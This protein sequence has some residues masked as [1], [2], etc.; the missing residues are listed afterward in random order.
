VIFPVPSAVRFPNPAIGESDGGLPVVV[1]GI[2][3]KPLNL[4]EYV[5]LRLA[6]LKANGVGVAVGIAGVG[7]GV[8]IGV[9]GVGIGR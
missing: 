1:L 7:L 4:V 5:P 3:Q 9:P 2:S 8:A 6:S